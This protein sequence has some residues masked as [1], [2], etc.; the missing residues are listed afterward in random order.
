MSRDPGLLVRDG[1]PS[2]LRTAGKVPVTRIA[3]PEEYRHL[4]KL[5]LV[6]AAGEVETC[7][8][9]DIPGHLADVLELVHA[10]AQDIGVWGTHLQRLRH[11]ALMERGGYADRVVLVEIKEE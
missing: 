11:Q 8:E 7:Q 2:H 4:L 1:E 9:A 3:A 6:L 10:L 5:G